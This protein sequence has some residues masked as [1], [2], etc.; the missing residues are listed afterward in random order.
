MKTPQREYVRILKQPTI[1]N[2]LFDLDGTLTDPREGI[3]RCI[4]YALER[5]NRSVPDQSELEAYIGPPLRATFA[6]IL[7]TSETALVERA[8]RLY[9]ERFAGVGLFENEVYE[10]VPAMLVSLKA[11]PYRLFVATSKAEIFAAQ[12]LEHFNLSQFFDGVYGSTLDGR[13][14]DKAE[15]LRHLLSSES[16]QSSETV[17]VGDRKH[18]VIAARQNS[19]LAL[20]V[21]YGYGSREELIAAR[22]DALCESPMALAAFLSRR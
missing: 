16:L 3:T 13:F 1:K 11:A 20:G 12:I 19:L 15:L 14:D 21:T 7:E 8:V 18:D 5:L 10:G 9:R 4:Q 22:A 2:V 6:T 17:M